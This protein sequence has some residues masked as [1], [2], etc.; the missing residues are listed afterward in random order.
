[1]IGFIRAMAAA[2][3]VTVCGCASGQLGGYVEASA[4]AANYTEDYIYDFWIQTAEGKRTGVGGVQVSEFSNGGQAGRICCG[5]MPGVGKSITVVWRVGGHQEEKAHWRTYSRDVVVKGTMPK[6]TT[7]HS[8]LLVR[9]F[10]GHEV[11]TELIPSDDLDPK[12]P[13]VDKLFSRQRVMRQQ[14][15]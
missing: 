8:Y 6:Q 3:L 11:E 5:L 2:L 13:R 4:W 14:G 9:F 12:N 7:S 15:E 10:S 1:M